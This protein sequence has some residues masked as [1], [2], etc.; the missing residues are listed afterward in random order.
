LERCRAA[1]AAANISRGIADKKVK[2]EGQVLFAAL[3]RMNNPNQF[4]YQARIEVAK[5][6][7]VAGHRDEGMNLLRTFPASGGEYKKLAD[8]LVDLFEKE[9]PQKGE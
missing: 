2:Q 6:M 1:Y 5:D 4:S 7:I 3:M 9:P 8:C